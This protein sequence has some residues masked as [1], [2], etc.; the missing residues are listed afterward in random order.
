MRDAVGSS[1]NVFIIIFLIALLSGYLAF[2]V[3]YTK[4]FHVKNEI[5]NY[6][7]EYETYEGAEQTI[8]ALISNY[9]NAQHY[10][11]PSDTINNFQSGHPDAVCRE[12]LG[13]CYVKHVS[14]REDENGTTLNGTYYTVYAFVNIEVPIIQQIFSAI[15]SNYNVR[16]DTRVLYPTK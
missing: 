4:A 13:F 16:G 15:S 9:K 11:V 5:I 8:D 2:S 7:E 3:N 6:I 12:T 14:S 1:V 10:V